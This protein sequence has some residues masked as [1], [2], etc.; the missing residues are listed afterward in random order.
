MRKGTIFKYELR[1]LLLSKEYLL[2]LI[3]VLAYSFSLLRGMVIFGTNYTAPFSQ[4]TFCTYVSS[5]SPILFILLLALCVRQFTPSERGAMAIIDAAPMPPSAF[6][7]IRYGAIACAFL[8]VAVLSAV[9][10]F[11]FYWVVFDYT[12]FGKLIAS[13]LM[14]FL[15]PALLIFGIAVLLGNW[16][17]V[18]IYIILAAVLFLGIFGVSLPAYIDIFGNSVTRTLYAGTHDFSFASAFVTGRIAF[19]FIGI[20]CIIL[21]LRLPQNRKTQC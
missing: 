9:I 17:P 18:L 20:A 19:V 12:A 16:K 3:T 15:P 11:V 8:I 14:L 7:E 1:R 4:W 2:L 6:R 5:V 13:G 10:C 21:S